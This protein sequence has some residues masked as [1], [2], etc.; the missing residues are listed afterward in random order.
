M[1]SIPRSVRAPEESRVFRTSVA[2]VLSVAVLTACSR[3]E[4]DPPPVDA[5][6]VIDAGTEIEPPPPDAGEVKTDAGATQQLTLA[7]F[8]NQML[9]KSVARMS[10]CNSG[11]LEGCLADETGVCAYIVSASAAGRIQYRPE[12]A[13]ACLALVDQFPCEQLEYGETEFDNA[14][15]R[16]IDGQVA[17]DGACRDNV[18]CQLGNWCDQTTW[19]CPGKCVAFHKVGES[20]SSGSDVPEC[21]PGSSCVEGTCARHLAEGELCGGTSA[22]CAWGSTCKQ[23]GDERRCVRNGACSYNEECMPTHWC[24]GD[25]R[26]ENGPVPGQCVPRLPLGA[27]CIPGEDSC[28]GFA[29]C[30]SDTLRCEKWGAIGES[31]GWENEWK[32]CIG[33]FCLQQFSDEGAG[34][35][36]GTCRAFGTEGSPCEY[37][38]GDE[39]GPE[40]LC[41]YLTPES[42]GPVCFVGC[43][44]QTVP[45]PAPREEDF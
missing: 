1:T 8:C 22:E 38:G 13:A 24:E 7:D 37:L 23:V 32:G 18:D 15:R 3:R 42:D 26:G 21:E 25:E 5:G 39:C 12:H 41:D 35:P 6:T 14:C 30:N 16:A 9:Q 27:T 19:T 45:V 28:I 36:G 4:D 20:C 44:T 34:E 43:R 29:S 10:A 40:G 33:G 2:V 17:T 11:L 31:C